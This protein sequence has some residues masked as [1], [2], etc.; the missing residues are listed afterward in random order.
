MGRSDAASGGYAKYRCSRPV[1]A[2]RGGSAA[3]PIREDS[4]RDQAARPARS[5]CRQ[6]NPCEIVQRLAEIIQ[7]V[8]TAW[9]K[10]RRGPTVVATLALFALVQSAHADDGRVP[11]A[12]AGSE[13]DVLVGVGVV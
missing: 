6:D 5:Q 13:Q 2:A 1:H 3:K 9:A 8:L 12:A 7:H 11:N 10:L 4:M